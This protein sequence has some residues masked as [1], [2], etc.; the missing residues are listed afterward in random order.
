MTIASRRPFLVFLA[1]A[2][3]VLAVEFLVVSSAAFRAGNPWLPVAVAVD[4]ALGL[5]LLA[6][7]LLVRSKRAPGLVVVPAGI[8]GILIAEW[9]LPS[10]RQG[11]LAVLELVLPLLEV[12]LLVALVLRLRAI[13]A[14]HRRHRRV[15]TYG[16]DALRLALSERLP[17]SLAAIV[18]AEI[19][20]LTLGLAGWFRRGRPSTDRERVFTAHR[21]SGYRELLIVCA[22]LVPVELVVAHLLV[23]RADVVAAWIVTGLGVYGVLWLAGDFHAMRVEPTIVD[24][25]HVHVRLGLRWRARIAREDL[26]AVGRHQPDGAD[27]DTV[28]IVPVGGPNVWMTA[29]RPVE[30]RGLFGITRRGRHV[31]LHVD[32]PDAFLAHLAAPTPG[33]SR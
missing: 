3:S 6:Y 23:M 31:A 21:A 13:V 22:F 5:P 24:D 9:L 10:D 8:A 29:R 4:L 26:V 33:A 27:G 30:A 7:V 16:S 1:L 32:E 20:L 19:T 2:L 12:I 25:A 17:P 15:E 28:E 11:A 14:A 18:S